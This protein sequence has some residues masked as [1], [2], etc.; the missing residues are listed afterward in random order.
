MPFCIWQAC[1]LSYQP[2]QMF[3]NM[4]LLHDRVHNV[5][6]GLWLEET[7]LRNSPEEHCVIESW[8][9]KWRGGTR[10][11]QEGSFSQDAETTQTTGERQRE[12]IYSSKGR[13]DPLKRSKNLFKYES[14]WRHLTLLLHWTCRL[15]WLGFCPFFVTSHKKS[16]SPSL[17]LRPPAL[18]RG[19]ARL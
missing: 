15:F 8:A 18:R 2:H 17:L 10:K 4:F 16:P 9:N 7:I 5:G 6:F 11:G 12:K 14:Y 19:M 13:N 3:W 1:G